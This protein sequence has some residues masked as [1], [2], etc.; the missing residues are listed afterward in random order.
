MKRI[1]NIFDEV[2][3]LENLRLADEKARKGKLKSY[4]VRVHD[5]NR[6]A[7]L[8]ALHES[9]KNGTFKTSKYHIFTIYE[10]KERLIYRLPYYPDRIL[11]H[12]IMNVLEPIW[13][14][15][16]NKNTYSC[17]KNRGIH[18][19]ANDVKQ[20]LKQDPDGT[21]Y[22][23]K[24]DVRK[25]YPS[26]DHELLK[27]VVRRK[28]KDGSLLALLDEIIDSVD[29]VPIG[30]YL[31]QYFANIYLAYFDHWLKEERGVKHYWRYA[32]DIVILAPNKEVL[33]GLLHS[34]RAYLHDNL[35]LQVKRNYQVFPVEARGIDFLGYVFFHTHTLLRKTI[36]QS[37]C[38]R[39]AKLNKRKKKPTKK[40]YKQKIA[41]WWGWCKYCDSINLVNK[42]SKT[43]PYE[44]KFNRSK[45]AL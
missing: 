28:I 30:N 31:S 41:S 29:G 20:A 36:K 14:S 35:K 32:D 8:L 42:L 38:R 23:L 27:G 43:F 26:I 19:C 2:I 11:H 22:C 13:V 15:V 39:V 34:I 5:K 18:K 7:N 6:E 17:I 45:R 12:A 16:F 1:G 10:P 44:I 33:H 9:L 3:S 4:G 37:L 25:F 40:E 21:R 24:I